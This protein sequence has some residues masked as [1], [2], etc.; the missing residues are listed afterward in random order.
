[1]LARSCVAVL[2]LHKDGKNRTRLEARADQDL[3]NPDNEPTY[4]DEV[5]GEDWDKSK[6]LSGVGPDA[7]DKRYFDWDESCVDSGQREKIMLTW[8]AFQDLTIS[9][10]KRLSDLMARLPDQPVGTKGNPNDENVKFIMAE[11][12]AYTQMFKA[13]DTGLTNVR[14]AFDAIT[15][16]AQVF[17]GRGGNKSGKPPA[18]RFICNADNHVKDANG[19]PLCG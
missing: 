9:A 17:Q 4:E 7:A 1:M 3:T 12:P 13:R 15:Q 6:I 19:G 18:L 11:D 10:S 8:V 14:N 2:T 16:N 5:T